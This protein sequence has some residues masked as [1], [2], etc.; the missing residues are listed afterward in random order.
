MHFLT[1]L[2][3]FQ[4]ASFPPP[5]FILKDAKHKEPKSG[6]QISGG[7]I[8]IQQ[9]VG[10][11]SSINTLTFSKDGRFLAAAKDFGRVVVWDVLKRQ[12]L[13]AVDT[14]Q[15]IVRA[16]ALSEDGSLLATGGEGDNFSFKLW[17]L[18]DGKLV[19]R[20]QKFSGYA[21]TAFFGPRSRT[22]IV[23]DNAATIHIL[24][25]EADK[26]LLDLPA[27]WTPLLY[28]DG[29]TLMTTSTLEYNFWSTVDWTL[30]RKTDRPSGG[31]STL[32][33]DPERDVLVL[34]TFPR[35][36]IRLAR[37]TT[38]EPLPAAPSPELPNF[39]SSAGGFAALASN[40]R[41]LL[42]HSG[43][44]LSVWDQRTGGTCASELMYSSAGT[45]SPDQTLLAAS[46]NDG[47]MA[48]MAGTPRTDGV[49]L[50]D[51][52]KLTARCIP[53]AQKN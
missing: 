9:G 42:G 28:P 2:L 1:L 41:F 24:D 23:A 46:K 3:V 35:G 31:P 53:G 49:W 26:R 22:L 4:V 6:V 7:S 52:A 12:F 39:N 8:T 10:T 38:G 30:Q 40:G 36:V 16:I 32:A 15:G 43:G 48:T 29:K 50:W 27:Q 21:R 5:D 14:G 19:R 17:S 25:A 34:A 20:Y 44:R 13:C 11:P 18:P 51:I 37:L 45:V 47:I 33:I